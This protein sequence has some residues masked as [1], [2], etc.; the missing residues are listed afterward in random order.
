[1]GSYISMALFLPQVLKLCI[2]ELYDACLKDDVN[3]RQSAS[4]I[5][6]I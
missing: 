6:Q 3:D 4:Q 5:N 1:M 2:P